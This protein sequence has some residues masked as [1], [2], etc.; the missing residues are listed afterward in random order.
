MKPRKGRVVY[1]DKSRSH[2]MDTREQ[3]VSLACDQLWRKECIII[4]LAMIA[5]KQ[6]AVT[7]MKAL[8]SNPPLLLFV[9]VIGLAG[10]LAMVIGHNIWVGGAL[11]VIVTLVGWLMLIRGTGLLMLPADK[12]IKVVEALSYEDF[13]TLHGRNAD[14]GPLPDLC[15]IQR[16]TAPS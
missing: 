7:T 4:A 6:R 5:R 11:P 10:G 13:F 12:V 9:E 8:V 1:S 16:L 2:D 15:R 3:A 14:P